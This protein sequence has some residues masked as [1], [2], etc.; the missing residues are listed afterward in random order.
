M[1]RP[2]NWNDARTESGSH[3]QRGYTCCF[4]N[5]NRYHSSLRLYHN[6]TGPGLAE[7]IQAHIAIPSG[8]QPV[9]TATTL[10]AIQLNNNNFRLFINQLTPSESVSFSVTISN[11]NAQGTI[12]TTA[13][14]SSS[15]PDPVQSNNTASITGTFVG[16]PSPTPTPTLTPT[17][18]PVPTPTPSPTPNPNVTVQSLPSKLDTA[19]TRSVLA[20]GSLARVVLR[21]SENTSVQD[22]YG[23][24]DQNGT[25]PTMLAGFQV[26]VGTVTTSMIAVTRLPNSS[27]TSY[28]IDFLL[29]DQAATGDHIPVTITNTQLTSTLTTTAVIHP[30]APSFW[31]LNGTANGPL[32]ILDADLLT[33]IDPSTHIPA[34]N[35]RRLLLFA[36]GSKTLVTQNTLTIRFTCESGRQGLIVH[37]FATTLS[38]LPGIQQIVVR[39]PTD[40]AGCGRTRISISDQH[41]SEVFLLIQ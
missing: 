21:I 3:Y 36:S 38:S 35:T 30:T 15:T 20:Q 2:N 27:A 14:L 17:P 6:H 18:T 11:T 25:W 4:R 22:T 12:T 41:D 34:D 28:A 19:A 37:D 33:A 29:P 9:A 1:D 10:G 13:I 16:S 40:L 31:S 39:I 32:L 24:P 7:N 23:K 26:K 8:L 5:K